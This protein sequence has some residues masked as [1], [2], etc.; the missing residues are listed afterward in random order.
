MRLATNRIGLGSLLLLHLLVGCASAPRP[1]VPAAGPAPAQDAPAPV[2]AL[3]APVALTPSL[4]CKRASPFGPVE[5]TEEQ[6]AS[7]HGA[8]ARDYAGLTTSKEQPLEVCGIRAALQA[9]LLLRC[10][11]GRSP[12][13]DAR[14][15]HASRAGSVGPGGRCE[16]IIDHYEVPCA[17]KTYAV[18]V[19]SYV[20]L[21]GTSVL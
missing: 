5:V 16:S 10:A 4:Q 7:R 15:A 11:D 13:R 21:P 18:Y 12:F 2:T 8:L 20:C 19:D 14:Q 17:E 3:P 1:V 9:L 6:Y